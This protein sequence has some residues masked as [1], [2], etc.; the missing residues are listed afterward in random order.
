MPSILVLYLV[1]QSLY[2]SCR[3]TRSRFCPGFVLVPATVASQPSTVCDLKP[4][5][6]LLI[7]VL[8]SRENQEVETIYGFSLSVPIS[9]GQD[10][11][12]NRTHEFHNCKPEALPKV[13]M[14]VWINPQHHT[15]LNPANVSETIFP[16]GGRTE[17]LQITQET[18][19]WDCQRAAGKRIKSGEYPTTQKTWPKETYPQM[20]SCYQQQISSSFRR[21]FAIALTCDFLSGVFENGFP[22]TG[23]PFASVINFFCAAGPHCLKNLPEQQMAVVVCQKWHSASKKRQKSGK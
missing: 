3:W 8:C 2:C 20:S 22:N 17:D 19:T 5:W 6:W 10:F 7:F 23:K 13:L 12:F 14:P 9:S 1:D 11:I 15:H 4:K 18:N 21:G 16:K